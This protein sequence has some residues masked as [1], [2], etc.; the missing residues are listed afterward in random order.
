MQGVDVSALADSRDEAH[1]LGLCGNH[2]SGYVSSKEAGRERP[3]WDNDA[4]VLGR[5]RILLNQ[6]TDRTPAS[7]IHTAAAAAKNTV[8]SVCRFSNTRR[9][10]RLW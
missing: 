5:Y 6:S 9:E 8:I 7:R 2:V 10:L 3:C 4:G 1:L